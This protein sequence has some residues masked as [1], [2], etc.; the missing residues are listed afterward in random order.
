MTNLINVC[1]HVACFWRPQ[2]WTQH[3]VITSTPPPSVQRRQIKSHR[4]TGQPLHNHITTSHLDGLPAVVPAAIVAAT[5]DCRLLTLD[6]NLNRIPSR[7]MAKRM[8]GRG[9]MQPNRLGEK[10]FHGY[11][12]A[13]WE[14]QHDTCTTVKE[15]HVIHN[16][17][18]LIWTSSLYMIQPAVCC[19]GYCV[20]PNRI[21]LWLRLSQLVGG[22]AGALWLDLP[23]LSPATIPDVIVAMSGVFVLGL[24]RA[25]A[26]KSTPSSAIAKITRGIGKMEPSR[27]NETAETCRTTH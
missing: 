1:G 26:L 21:S 17:P 7:A 19:D 15:R 24:I 11:M 2:H 22:L 18:R 16:N 4:I 3:A 25:K 10:R 9:N 6:I 13:H 14:Q 5:G 8:R 23:R 27:L 12:C 20:C